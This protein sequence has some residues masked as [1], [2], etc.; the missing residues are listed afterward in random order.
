MYERTCVTF[1]RSFLYTARLARRLQYQ[2]VCE[3][4]PRVEPKRTH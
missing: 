2:G 4:G 3:N 1:S